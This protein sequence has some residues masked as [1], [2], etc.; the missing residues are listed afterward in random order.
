MVRP[1]IQA[2]VNAIAAVL[3][4]IAHELPTHVAVGVGQDAPASRTRARSAMDALTARVI[5]VRPVYIG[6]ASP[7]EIEN[8]AAFTDSLAALDRTY[9]ASAR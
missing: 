7:A 2:T 8:F 1:E 9:R 5:Q 6:T 3:D 4:E